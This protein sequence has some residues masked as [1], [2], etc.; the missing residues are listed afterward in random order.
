[1]TNKVYIVS[2]SAGEYSDHHEWYVAASL[3]E[4]R[5]ND[6]KSK[7]NE[8]TE[9]IVTERKRVH[10]EFEVPYKASHPEPTCQHE[11]STPNPEFLE[12]KISKKH[13][14]DDVR[15]IWR[16]LDRENNI[17]LDRDRQARNQYIDAMREWN[18]EFKKAAA[19]YEARYTLPQHLEDVSHMDNQ[20][21]TDAMYTCAEV[22]LV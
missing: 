18:V 6:I 3:S 21:D 17:R 10:D 16:R 4:E 20:F 9:Y 15:A 2:G 12:M 1:M 7:L 14:G 8:L 13:V 11:E 19:A 5:A 22:D